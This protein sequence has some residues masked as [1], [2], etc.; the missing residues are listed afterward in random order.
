MSR[1][2]SSKTCIVCGVTDVSV[3]REHIL[4]RLFG[5]TN[6]PSNIAFVCAN[7]NAAM[8]DFP[9]ERHFVQYLTSLLEKSPLFKNV[10]AEARVPGTSFRADI[11]A[12]RVDTGE[13]LIIECKRWSVMN[14]IR[15][16]DALAQLQ[17]YLAASGVKQGV[18]AFPGYVDQHT[19]SQLSHKRIDLWDL[20]KIAAQ[21]R[22][23]IAQVED[24]YF[25]AIFQNSET[26]RSIEDD[27]IQQLGDCPVGTPGWLQ[28]QKLVGRILS[29]LFC[30]PL[31]APLYEH[32][33]FSSINRRDFIF[34]NYASEGFWC[35]LQRRY[36]ADYIVVDAKNAKGKIQKSHILQVANYLKEHGVGRFGM[37]LCRQGPDRGAIATLREQWVLHGK[38]IIVLTHRDIEDMLLAK[39]ASG[40]PSSV[41][42]AHIQR[43]RLSM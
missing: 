7:C 20:Q 31:N 36:S 3:Q 10:K 37:V 23:Q 24:K 42:G 38:L 39:A 43:F 21:F 34:P 12:E 16:K 28:Y 14:E 9:L 8:A 32:S 33:D 40:D 29:Y 41:I 35:F 25:K 30:P 13:K 18:I 11:I 1:M 6:D 17:D 2:Q 15:L 5:G 27:L 22:A 26:R 4:P 19:A